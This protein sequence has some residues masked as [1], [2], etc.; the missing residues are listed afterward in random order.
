MA[1]EYDIEQLPEDD[2]NDQ[3]HKEAENDQQNQGDKKQGLFKYS[4]ISN[5]SLVPLLIY[6]SHLIQDLES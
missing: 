5:Q 2:K 6:L 1:N 3:H 4:K